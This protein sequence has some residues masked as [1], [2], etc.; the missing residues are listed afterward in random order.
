MCSD[1][2]ESE[3]T[4]FRP[5][6]NRG[7]YGLLTFLSA[8]L[9]TTELWWQMNHRK[10]FRTLTLYMYMYMRIYMCMY[11]CTYVC[12]LCVCVCIY[13]YIYA[14]LHVYV[15][16]YIWICVCIYTSP[17]A[18]LQRV[19]MHSQVL[20]STMHAQVCTLDRC[21][22]WCQ[23]EGIVFAGLTEPWCRTHV[24]PLE[25][26][27]F[28]ASEGPSPKKRTQRGFQR[29]WLVLPKDHIPDKWALCWHHEKLRWQFRDIVCIQTIICMD[30]V[31]HSCIAPLP[32]QW[33]ALC[34]FPTSQTKDVL[35][36]GRHAGIH[37]RSYK[38]VSHTVSYIYTLR[39][40]TIKKMH[41]LLSCS[42]DKLF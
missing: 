17:Y 11:P 27:L 4:C 25:G 30:R 21:C 38:K 3:V 35:T 15:Y 2:C 39:M 22:R 14:C 32:V 5:E 26:L 34:P 23:Q 42:I 18:F 7:P 1:P 16:M 12:V 20:L 24:A 10:S 37:T 29:E 6:S 36:V 41:S 19:S 31:L 8:A 9:S 33:H 28:T 40:Y 13:I